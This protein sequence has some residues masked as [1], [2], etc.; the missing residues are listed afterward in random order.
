MP[1]N[2]WNPFRKSEE[3]DGEAPD[4]TKDQN[5][6]L[7]A[8]AAKI[9]ER[10]KP[11]DDKIS[12]VQSE[13]NAIK[14]EASKP[15]A[16]APNNNQELTPEQRDANEKRALLMMNAQTNAR[17][18]ERDCL[19]TVPEHWRHLIPD[20]KKIFAETPINVKLQANYAQVCANAVDVLIGRAARAGG[21]RTDGARF[22]IEDSAARTG[23]DESPLND[24]P[25]WQSDDRTETASETLRKMGID[26]KKFAKDLRDGRLQ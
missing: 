21:V 19:D 23:G 6:L 17:L 7:D 26:E 3:S 1:S 4:A 25:A 14:E 9:D 22:Y 18:T 8:F 2:R 20:L 16:E 24:F 10:L 11:L 12:A 5:A 15:P 13:W